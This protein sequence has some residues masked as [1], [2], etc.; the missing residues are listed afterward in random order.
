LSSNKILSPPIQPILYSPLCGF[1]ENAER[2]N[3]RSA[4]VFFIVVLI[5]EAIADKCFLELLGLQV[6]KGIN[7][8]F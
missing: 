1:V 8:G 5:V 4:M 6:G 7:V 2:I 3:G